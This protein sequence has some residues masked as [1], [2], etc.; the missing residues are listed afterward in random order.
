M[1]AMCGSRHVKVARLC[2]WLPVGVCLHVNKTHPRSHTGVERE[3]HSDSV[4]QV[5]CV[6]V[7]IYGPPPTLPTLVQLVVTAFLSH[8]HGSTHASQAVLYRGHMPRLSKLVQGTWQPHL[9]SLTSGEEE[10]KAIRPGGPL[11]V[12]CIWGGGACL[13]HRG[14]CFLGGL[15]RAD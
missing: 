9:P 2:R 13:R 8:L 10:M 1:G 12:Q 4:C 5:F 15:V 3:P 11:L 7:V 6:R 14:S